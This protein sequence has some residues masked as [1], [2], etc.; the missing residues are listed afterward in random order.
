MFVSEGCCGGC[1][2]VGGVCGGDGS[3]RGCSGLAVALLV[4]IIAILLLLVVIVVVA[5][6]ESPL[7]S[8]LLQ[9]VYSYEGQIT[10]LCLLS[11]WPTSY[12]LCAR[13]MLNKFHEV[14]I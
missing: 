7:R 12:Q 10:K 3:S 11:K 5:E 1:V 14:R 2:K 6:C 9:R 4:I 8:P 13:S